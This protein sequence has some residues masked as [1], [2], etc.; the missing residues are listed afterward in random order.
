MTDHCSDMRYKTDEELKAMRPLVNMDKVEA[1]GECT[2]LLHKYLT[3]LDD[4][5]K[6]HLRDEFTYKGKVIGVYFWEKWL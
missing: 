2:S 4:G 5:G 3:Q 1:R 6:R